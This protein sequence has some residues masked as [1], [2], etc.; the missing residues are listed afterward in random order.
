MQGW[1]AEFDGADE[2][3]RALPAVGRSTPQG[4]VPGRCRGLH[5]T[6]M[7]I[8]SA[9]RFPEGHPRPRTRPRDWRFPLESG[10]NRANA[11]CQSECVRKPT[12][13]LFRVYRRVP[14]C[15]N[16]TT[17]T[18]WKGRPTRRMQT[19]NRSGRGDGRNPQPTGKQAFRRSAAARKPTGRGNRAS[20]REEEVAF[21]QRPRD[22]RAFPPGNCAGIASPPG[23]RMRFA[24]SL[25]VA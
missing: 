19:A 9:G 15:R 25:V 16:K 22:R 14:F 5:G 12:G 18:A 20:P 17:A 2:P 10:A 1:P 23:M 11:W 13:R 4:K 8:Q 6:G 3:G 21:W 24:P 7:R